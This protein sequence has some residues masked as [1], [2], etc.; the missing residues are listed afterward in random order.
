[1]TCFR[2]VVGGKVYLNRVNTSYIVHIFLFIHFTIITIY[3]ICFQAK[4]VHQR[5]YVTALLS[6]HLLRVFETCRR[7]ESVSQRCTQDASSAFYDL[8][9]PPLS[10]LIKIVSKQNWSTNEGTSH[11]FYRLSYDVFPEYAAG[12][13]VYLKAVHTNHFVHILRFIHSTIITIHHTCFKAKI[14]H[15]QWYFM[16]LPP[17]YYVFSE[18]AAGREVYLNG[19]SS[20]IVHTFLFIRFTIFTI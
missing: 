7:L 2:N 10:R 18:H 12:K 20:Y 5:A 19:V 3:R 6:P 11:H 16:S 9:N 17:P 4:V 8:Y 1:M 14:V 13:E 15:Q